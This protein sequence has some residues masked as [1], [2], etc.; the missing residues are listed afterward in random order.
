MII[1][2]CGL[3]YLGVEIVIDFKE[4]LRDEKD[5]LSSSYTIP[6]EYLDIISSDNIHRIRDNETFNSKIR[7]PGAFAEL[8]STFDLIIYKMPWKENALPKISFEKP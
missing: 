6:K 7:N 4:L 5:S 1:V 2:A 8:D 3:I